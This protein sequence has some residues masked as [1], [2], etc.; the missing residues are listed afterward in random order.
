MIPATNMTTE[1]WKRV[2]EALVVWSGI[3]HAA[4]PRLKADLLVEHY[5]E[6]EAARLLPL[7]KGLYRDF[8]S[9]DAA[10]T[11]AD[12]AEMERQA[13]AEFRARHRDA[14]DEAIK[15]LV[16]CYNWNNRSPDYLSVSGRFDLGGTHD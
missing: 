12:H 4:T 2:T 16:W 14:P 1:E 15:V 11:A 13:T 6:A 7:V 10:L 8:A 9:S 5:G 3:E